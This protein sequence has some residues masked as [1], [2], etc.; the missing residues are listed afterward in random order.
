MPLRRAVVT[1][2]LI[3]EQVKPLLEKGRIVIDITNAET[4]CRGLKEKLAHVLELIANGLPGDGEIATLEEIANA[5]ETKRLDD[6]LK[7]TTG[8]NLLIEGDPERN[9]IEKYG[10]SLI[11]DDQLGEIWE[12]DADYDFL[13]REFLFNPD[14][15]IFDDQGY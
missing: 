7:R 15:Y 9:W 14:I 11:N 1:S 12:P 6:F 5:P 8:Y 13:M 10:G 3:K 4:D 2:A